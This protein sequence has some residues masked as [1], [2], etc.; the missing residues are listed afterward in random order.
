MARCRSTTRKS[1][2]LEPSFGPVATSIKLTVRM[3]A[4]STFKSSCQILASDAKCTSL[5]G[6]GSWIEF[7][8]LRPRNGEDSLKQPPAFLHIGAEKSDQSAN[9]SRCEATSIDSET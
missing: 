6:K 5:W 3:R 8:K 2:S 9:S 4:C 7:S 1:P